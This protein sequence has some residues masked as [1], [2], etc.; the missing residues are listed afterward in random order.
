MRYTKSAER[1]FKNGIML[2]AVALG[3]RTVA[4]LFNAYITRTVGAE[5]VGLFTVV[6]TVYSFAVTFAT[7]GI[8][9]TVTRLVAQARGEGRECGGIL[10][11]AI[12]WALIFS[13]VSSLTL[14]FGA[15]F[16]GGFVLSDARCADCLKILAPSLVPIALI[17]VF[18]GYFVGIRRVACNAAVQIA[19]QFFK[20]VLTV[21]LLGRI[22]EIS[23]RSAAVTLSLGITLTELACFA[24][25]FAEFLI[26]R[27]RKRLAPPEL[28]EVITGAAP[29]AASTYIRQ[30]LLTVE[31]ILIPR[32]LR[33]FG[34]GQSESL[35]SYGML[36]GMALPTVIY[37]MATLSSFAGLLVPEFAE[38]GAAKN[39][40]GMKRLASRALSTT[41]RYAIAVSAVLLFFSEELGYVVWR[42]RDAGAYIAALA[43]VVPI[44]YLD[45]VTDSILK[46]IGEQVFSMW[47]NITDSLLSIFLVWLL[48]PRLGILGYAVCIVVMELYNFVLSFL[49]L[50]QK[51]KFTIDLK[52][53][54]V[55]PIVSATVSASLASLAFGRAGA[56]STPL[57]LV[58][59][60][61][62]VIC[63]YV[64]IDSGL[65]LACKLSKK[66]KA[67]FAEISSIN[68]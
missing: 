34:Q 68:T 2:T 47:I 14:F 10:S 7:S 8:S 23:A 62:F 38:R 66:Q 56:Q 5:G 33:L 28:T 11:G 13:I 64:A 37:P 50:R 55:F 49:R 12:I 24:V 31:H 1:F 17:S 6:M 44:M 3:I 36:H 22:S 45:H 63:E 20:I 41:L 46:G 25:I 19:G 67:D 54:L 48:I 29:L 40:A 58:L 53:A 39:E 43:T 35:E 60:I 42:S 16:F 15:D 9:L 18:S 65:N 27:R 30:A 26:D 57:W 4:L 51:I 52:S 32:G 21:Y 59:Q 61:I